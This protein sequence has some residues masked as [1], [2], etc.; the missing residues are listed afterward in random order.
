MSR[1]KKIRSVGRAVLRVDRRRAVQRERA[2]AVDR[3]RE[4]RVEDDAAERDARVVGDGVAAG[5]IRQQA[6]RRHA[7]AAGDRR[8]PVGRNR[9]GAV[10]VDNPASARLRVRE[11]RAAQQRCGCGKVQDSPSILLTRLLGKSHVRTPAKAW[12]ANS[13]SYRAECLP[14]E[15][16]TCR[17]IQRY[18]H[19]G[20]LQIES[21]R[22][23]VSTQTW[24]VR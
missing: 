14:S 9:P 8:I 10:G 7:A 5:G 19:S 1:R 4:W 17:I 22:F 16:G 13:R 18:P 11:S 15:G 12:E 24:P 3:E 6:E 2:A 20:R 21:R 23:I